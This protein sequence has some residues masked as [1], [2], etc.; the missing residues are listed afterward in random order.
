[1]AEAHG[2]DYVECSAKTGEGVQEAIERLVLQLAGN[3]RR[4]PGMPTPNYVP[5]EALC[6]AAR[7]A[8]SS[9]ASQEQNSQLKTKKGMRN[10]S[11]Q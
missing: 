8:L 7:C 6:R 3:W 10:C 1:M 5:A 4:V 2:V 11:L 9:R